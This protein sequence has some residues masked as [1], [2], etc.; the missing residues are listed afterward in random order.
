MHIVGNHRINYRP[1]GTPGRLGSDMDSINEV[2]VG[3]CYKCPGFAVEQGEHWLD[4]GANIG[5]FALYCQDKG[6]TTVCYEPD[7]ENFQLLKMNCPDAFCVNKAVTS[8][9][10]L[11]L[12]FYGSKKPDNHWRN[13]QFPTDEYQE[14]GSFSNLWAGELVKNKF[15]GVKMDIEGSEGP[16]ID[17]WLLP[18]CD[19]LCL[20][21]HTSRDPNI[22][23]LFR[24]LIILKSKFKQVVYPA[25]FDKA[26]VNRTQLNGLYQ[27]KFDSLIF[28]WSPIYAS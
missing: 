17:G 14:V 19:K 4:L 23:N 12:K 5:A 15:S 18:R 13:T 7:L 11:L 10:E 8:S 9:K 26:I 22:D 1:S 21:Y 2:L 25:D 20:E 6:G 27:P 28:C 3:E 24:R 16:I